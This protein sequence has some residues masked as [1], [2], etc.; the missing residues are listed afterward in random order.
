VSARQRQSTLKA[1]LRQLQAVDRGRPKLR[2]QDALAGY[3]EH[4]VVDCR[5]DPFGSYSG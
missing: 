2:W 4:S 1:P 5:D 3:D